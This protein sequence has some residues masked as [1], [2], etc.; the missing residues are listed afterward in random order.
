MISIE[1]KM[2]YG[3]LRTRFVFWK[4]ESEG[5]GSL[6]KDIRVI[7]SFAPDPRRCIR[8]R[9]FGGLNGKGYLEGSWFVLA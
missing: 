7:L 2:T 5:K 4:E 6:K 8:I 3:I 1:G 9:C